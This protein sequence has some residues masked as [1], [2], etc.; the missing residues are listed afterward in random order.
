MRKI[1]L[2]ICG[3]LTVVSGFRTVCAQT[4]I[5]NAD[6]E[7]WDNHG[8]YE[9]P[10]SWSTPNYVTAPIPFFGVSEVTKSTDHESGTYSARLETKHLTLPPTDVPG[11]MTLG[12]LTLDLAAGTYSIT[13]GVPVSDIPTHLAGF[14]KFAPQ[15]GDSCAIGIGFFK[16]IAGVR[17][18][19]GIGYFSTKAATT[20]W[21][22]FSAW[23]YYD[24]IVQPDTMNIIALSTAQ[25]T[26]TPGTVLYVDAL[27]LDYTVG[28]KNTDPQ[29]GVQFYQDKETKRMLIFFDF[30]S[31]RNTVVDLFDMRGRKIR[32]IPANTVQK[33]REAFSYSGLD[34]GIYIVQVIHNNLKITKKYFFN[35]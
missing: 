2:L 18:S 30:P 11:F 22:P 25:E 15:G 35:E 26:M 8:S 27:W 7:V 20:D 19:V 14:Y 10:H 28:V 21:T 9:D 29:V 16:T 34:P 33:G 5:P 32:E 17:D 24:T 13:G 31:P 23:I 1:F 3:L 4:V 12:N 6:F